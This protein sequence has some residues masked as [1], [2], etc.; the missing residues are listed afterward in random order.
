[1]S[2]TDSC[3]H[4]V[5]TR[6]IARVSE[7]QLSTN[8]AEAVEQKAREAQSVAD[9]RR[10]ELDNTVMMEARPMSPIMAVTCV[11]TV[12]ADL[13]AVPRQAPVALPAGRCH[14]A[15]TLCCVLPRQGCAVADL[16]CVSDSC[17]A[18]AEL[19]GRPLTEFAQHACCCVDVPCSAVPL[20][21]HQ[22]CDASPLQHTSSRGVVGAVTDWLRSTATYGIL[23]PM[24]D[25]YVTRQPF[26]IHQCHPA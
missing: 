11:R 21:K 7:V 16:P 14:A 23:R 12:T 22:Q 5:C 24:R 1:M 17:N 25:R 6:P 18:S 3:A 4:D 2:L 9:R 8:A 20:K 10:V 15:A 13:V 26:C 19:V